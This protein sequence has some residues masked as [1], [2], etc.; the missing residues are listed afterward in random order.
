MKR[1][2][3]LCAIA[4]GLLL[5][6]CQQFQDVKSTDDIAG[7]S[8]TVELYINAD[9]SLPRPSSYTV[10]CTNFA[11]RFEVVKT[12][13]PNEDA[14]IEGLIPGIYTITISGEAP[15]DGFTFNYKGSLV[16]T[17][18]V[19]NGQKMKVEVAASKSGAIILKEIFFCG[20]RTPKGGSYFR[21]QYYELYNNGNEIQYLDGL[22]LGNMLP[23]NATANL[24]VWPEE[25]AKTH[26]FMAVA[27]QIPGSGTDYPLAPGE[28][29]IIAQMADNH[30]QEHLNPT[31]PVNLITAEF[32]T[33]V[34][35]T[36]LIKDNPAINLDIAFW[37]RQVPQWL[38]TVSGGAYALFNPE[39]PIDPTK[40]VTPIGSTEKAYPI[41]YDDVI[42]AVELV[43]DE[44]KMKLKRVPAVLDAGATFVGGTYISKS[45][46]RKVKERLPDGRIIF[47]DTNDSTEDFEIQDNPTIRRY[48][49]ASPS[50]NTWSK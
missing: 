17:Q 44:T 10:K 26:I 50:W 21:D 23:Q 48:G 45:V 25:Y 29:A 32:E 4:C 43:S 27:W 41:K 28:S 8:T 6:S 3:T 49:T 1:L 13:K 46:S 15:K 19:T 33:F 9:E 31:S 40:Y 16:N 12:V 24:P 14:V 35:S 37:P 39:N 5:H 34:N 20:S 38:V 47:L 11:D 2:T 7:I 22:C 42:D 18:I 36:S 30:Q